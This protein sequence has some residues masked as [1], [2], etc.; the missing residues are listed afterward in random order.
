[1]ETWGARNSS[2]VKTGYMGLLKHG[3]GVHGA[4]VKLEEDGV[5][6]AS[7]RLGKS[8]CLEDKHW[9]LC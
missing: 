7:V 1:M 8:L 3:D 4:S 2:G 9:V 6:G 5:H